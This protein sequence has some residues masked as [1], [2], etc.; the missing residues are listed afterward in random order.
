MSIP[1]S[2][3]LGNSTD[4]TNGDTITVINFENV[5]SLGTGNDSIRG[6]Q[7]P[8]LLD[9]GLGS[10]T[11]IAVSSG[12]T[13]LGGEG[14]DS[15]Y[16]AD[17]F[18]NILGGGAGND[19]FIGSSGADTLGGEPNRQGSDTLYGG[20]GADSLIGRAGFDGFYYAGNNEIGDTISSFES[21][22]DKIY[23][24]STAFG[25][26]DASGSLTNLAAPGQTLRTGLDFFFVPSGQDYSTLGGTFFGGSTTLPAIIFDSN[27][28]GGGTL[29]WDWNGGGNVNIGGSLSAIAVIESGT[30]NVSDI[31]IF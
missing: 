14:N 15:L 28:G 5:I 1:G 24:R 8:N 31:V 26:F 23:L 12:N 29:Y 17:G 4:Q 2:I 30:V 9:G 22:T 11:L 13:L 19:F 10:D 7:D 27:A 18:A 3:D 25:N 6:S 21:G 20:L 16:G